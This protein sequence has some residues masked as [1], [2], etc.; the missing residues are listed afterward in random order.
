MDEEKIIVQAEDENSGY[1]EIVEF[2]QD[3][4]QDETVE[5]I[6]VEEQDIIIVESD[7]A[8]PSL[9]DSN[10][11]MRHDLLNNRDMP[12]QHPIGAITGLDNIL[13]VLSSTR[14][15][16][17]KS[18]G[19]AEL[20]EWKSD[21]KAKDVGYFVSLVNDSKGNTYVD[22]YNKDYGAYGV[23][24]SADSVGFY[25]Y[26]DGLYSVLDWSSPN[27]LNDS[28]YAKVCLLG[29]VDIRISEDEYMYVNVGDY[30]V[31]NDLGCASIWADDKEHNKHKAG[32][33]V[34]SKGAKK[35]DSS[36]LVAWYYVSISLVPQNDQL[37]HIV[38][39]LKNVKVNLENVTIEIGGKV[40]DVYDTTI[41]VSNKVDGF[42][43]I[44]GD[45]TSKVDNQLGEIEKVV[46]DANNAVKDA[47]ETIIKVQAEYVDAKSAAQ[48][49]RDAVGG[50]LEDIGKLKSNMDIL[51]QGP[52]GVAGFV[53]QANRDSA[54]LAS[55]TQ[56][57]GEN[58]TDITSIIQKIDE[59]GAAIQHIVSHVDKYT[60]GMYSPAYGLTED[61]TYVLQP[62]HIYVPTEDHADE[63]T[64]M[65]PPIEFKFGKSYE[66]RI[67]DIPEV[68]TW[69]E[70]KDIYIWVLYE[71]MIVA[72]EGFN[73]DNDGD[74]WYCRDGILINDKYHYSPGTLYCWD[75]TKGLWVAV[76]SINDNSTS[77]VVS[78]VTQTADKLSSSY[79]DLKGNI[80]TVEQTVEELKSVVENVDKGSLSGIN[81][82]AEKIMMGIYKPESGSTTL[83]LLLDGM[84]S[85]AS[86][87]EHTMVK[88]VLS[89]SHDSYGNKYSK[90]PMWSGENFVFDDADIDNLNGVYYFDS[91][92]TTYYCKDVSDGYE[93]YSVKNIAIASLKS[94]V[95]DV[96]SELESWT[97]FKAG[98][99]ETMTSISQSSD[100]DGAEISSVVFGEYRKCININLDITDEDIA[101]IPLIR[102]LSAPNYVENEDGEKVFVFQSLPSSDGMYCIPLNGDGSSYYK[103]L[104]DHG[105][106]IIGY[107]EYT[108]K[109]SNYAAIMQ[110]LDQDGSVIGLVAGNN[111]VEGGI[112]V[113]AINDSSSILIDANKIGINGTT[114]FADILN[115][116][117]TTISGNY[118]RTGIL[119]SNNYKKPIDGEIFAQD[120]TRF[121]LNN[122]S[123]NSKNFNLDV[124]GNASITGRIT[125]T[126]GYIGN[127]VN[128]FLI[129]CD[130][131]YRHVVERTGEW[132]GDYYFYIDGLYYYFVIP[133]VELVEGDEIVLSI[134]DKEITISGSTSDSIHHVVGTNEIDT[135][136]IPLSYEDISRYYISNNQLELS[137]STNIGTY[138]VYIAPD[139]IGLGNGNFYVDN[140]GNLFTHG[141]V[142]LNN[143]SN[144]GNTTKKSII[145]LKD[146]NMSMISRTTVGDKTKE[147]GVILNDGN[148]S[149]TGNIQLSGSITWSASNGPVKVLYATT[150]DSSANW[151]G[152]YQDGDKFAKYSYDGGITWSNAIQIKGEDGRAG[153]DG[154]DGTNAEVTDEMIFNMLTNNGKEKG[155]FPFRREN[156]FD[157]DNTE[158][159]LFIN[160]DYINSGI[161]RGITVQSVDESGNTVEMNSG[162]ISFKPLGGED[163]KLKLGFNESN[164][165]YMIFG[166][167]TMKGY[168]V[169]NIPVIPGT[170]V[171]HKSNNYFKMIFRGSDNKNHGIWFYD[172]GSYSPS[173]GW[174]GSHIGFGESV[175]DFGSA[176]V[177]GLKITFG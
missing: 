54:K 90:P 143:V 50:V 152:D 159:Q 40:D 109:S 131:R 102:Y 99:N 156:P 4:N 2:E 31:P 96:E 140:L 170:A 42:E 153:A 1:V 61:Q 12:D 147:S 108:M 78:F 176:T 144:S 175:I 141:G 75:G 26:Q 169:D 68:Y 121:D 21:T 18:G 79:E 126:S 120:G 164:E 51:A 52:N 13:D 134:N 113:Q 55:L 129:E 173:M 146:G 38:E 115:P 160:A 103:L 154:I 149:L 28:R 123:I 101:N 127:E 37:S 111:D 76:A 151:H 88:H 3:V 10:E 137:P 106:G 135:Y 34:T 62:G 5:Y 114:T 161:L 58:G 130:K 87:V 136:Y 116:G 64:Y 157:P 33:R 36:D 110:K 138:G 41:N 72:T 174:T 97:K 9:G 124:N 172:D 112:F 83:E 91:E 60:V 155:I 165:P 86:N 118:I 65:Y 81:Q 8:F 46:K 7:D 142:T 25:G 53:A 168:D 19:F 11:L 148:L 139:G 166:Q 6:D 15:V 98:T 45:V 47:N 177:K 133:D 70:G 132:G 93:V 32:Y 69:V 89:F 57:F 95:S 73:Q 94:H 105:L 74:L 71:D 162:F 171:L 56:A 145:E 29:N 27:R 23:T 35:F 100:D 107:E 125:A 66:W 24:V 14:I 77:R 128:G 16:Y 59:N 49:A 48:E 67:G 43:N 82:T 85:V 92:S 122:G 163:S 39:D 17:A 119:E 84:N 150:S 117:T 104:Y 44:L 22:I 63:D 30:V 20:R 167:G 158:N 80:S